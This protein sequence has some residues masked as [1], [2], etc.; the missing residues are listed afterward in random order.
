MCFPFAVNNNA[1]LAKLI[2][3]LTRIQSLSQ[4]K[5]RSIAALAEA[6]TLHSLAEVGA[7]ELDD[8][9]HFMKARTHALTNAVA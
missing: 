6:G 3:I 7:L 8:A 5:S 4:T 1:I 9:A 2:R